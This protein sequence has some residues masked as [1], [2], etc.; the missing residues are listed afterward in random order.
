L[1]RAEADRIQAEA[2]AETGR[3]QAQAEK[4]QA[5]ADADATRQRAIAEKAQAEADAYQKRTQADAVAA[6]ER[7][8]VRQT[9]RDAAHERTLELLP[10]LVII[11][12]LVLAGIMATLALARHYQPSTTPRIE[13]VDPRLVVL[14]QDQQYRLQQLER[15]TYHLIAAEQRRQIPSEAKHL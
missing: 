6:T 1:A 9:E 12:G 15:A 10:F 4:A 14:L 5:E 11:V 13:T 7:S 3:I 8:A 2:Q